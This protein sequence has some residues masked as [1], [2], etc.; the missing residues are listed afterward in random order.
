MST[1]Q[2]QHNNTQHRQQHINTQTNQIKSNL[3]K[4]NQFKTKSSRWNYKDEADVKAVDAGFDD[5]AI[6]YDV[7]WLD[8]EH[9]VGK[10]YMTWDSSL[11]PDPKGMQEDLAS[12]GRKMVA[13]IDP[14]GAALG[15]AR[16]VL[17]CLRCLCLFCACAR[18]RTRVCL[19]AASCSSFLLCHHRLHTHSL[20]LSL[21]H[22]HMQT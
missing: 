6:P 22:T 20:S 19:G 5:H 16:S 10:R 1:K 7:L 13:I 3:I 8:I 4:S 21:S 9:T 18:M 11:F 17:R 14:H 15:A 12:R 2:Q